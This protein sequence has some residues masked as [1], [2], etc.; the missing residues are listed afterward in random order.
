MRNC[1]VCK[2][3]IMFTD[4]GLVCPICSQKKV[5]NVRYRTEGVYEVLSTENFLVS[6]KYLNDKQIQDVRKQGVTILVN[7]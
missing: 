5:L 7:Y 6:G 1:P 4:K 2:T 3:K